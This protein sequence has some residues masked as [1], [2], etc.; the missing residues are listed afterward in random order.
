MLALALTIHEAGI[1]SS[2]GQRKDLALDPDLAEEWT[3]LSPVRDYAALAM[4][5]LA[6]TVEGDEGGRHAAG[7]PF[8]SAED[9]QAVDPLDVRDGELPPRLDVQEDELV[10]GDGRV[11]QEVRA[12]V[13]SGGVDSEVPEQGGCGDVET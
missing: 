10:D 2:H 3:G 11:G 1:D 9:F 12:R 7:V 5:T 4:T 8:P 6:K 13:D